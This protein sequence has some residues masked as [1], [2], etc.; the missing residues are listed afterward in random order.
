MVVNFSIPVT[1]SDYRASDNPLYSYAKLKIFYVGMTK[2]KRLF[3]KEFS[4]NL[5]KSLPLVPVVAYYDSEKEDF[6]GHKRDV[7]Y[8]YGVVPEST[9]IEYIKE[10]GKEFAL[11]DIIL[12]TGRQDET[13]EI[14]QKIVGKQHSL[15]L[16]PDDTTYVI[17]KDK[18]GRVLNIE[19]KTGSLLGL[20]VLGDDEQPAFS[21]SEFFTSFNTEKLRASF[22]D[23]IQ[24]IESVK[25][26]K[27]EQRGEKMDKIFETALSFIKRTYTERVSL[28]SRAISEKLNYEYFYLP[29][30]FDNEVIVARFDY[31][32]EEVVFERIG[33]T[34]GEDDSV[35]FTEPV[36]V[37]P[38]YLTIEE[39]EKWENETDVE[40][41]QK[42]NENK[43]VQENIEGMT[44][45]EKGEALPAAENVEI[46]TNTSMDVSENVEEEK[47]QEQGQAKE[48]KSQFSGTPLTDSERAE[49]ESYRKE[50]KINY[51][52]TF[53]GLLDN[54]FLNKIKNDVD[55]YS[56]DDL[57]VVLSKEFTRVSIENAKRS[58]QTKKLNPLYY[59]SNNDTN[60][61]GKITFVS[62]VEKYK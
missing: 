8:I 45:S 23:F 39:I 61:S 59:N 31:E 54:S 51:I 32:T 29:Q 60:P 43:R 14:A 35:E 18:D 53:E 28:L 7:Q 21:G 58:I 10:D 40:E 36:R 62:L 37:I 46:T 34:L 52:S 44:T 33:Y 13:G 22:E 15:E 11:C 6:I 2:D 9:K 25:F 48:Q 38:R 27:N 26:T 19:F 47:T 57:E 56:L 49:L 55:N 3:T 50:K 24:K 30:V 20:S 1:L 16:N 12:Y 42:N 5:L 41:F 17:N 4:D